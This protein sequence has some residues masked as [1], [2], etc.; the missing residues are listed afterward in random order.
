MRDIK[1]TNAASVN[2]KVGIPPDVLARQL[3]ECVQ[4]AQAQV[5][6]TIKALDQ[7]LIAAIERGFMMNS[8]VT[9]AAEVLDIAR[10][11]VVHVVLGIDEFAEAFIRVRDLLAVTQRSD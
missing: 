11:A 5:H 7:I 2:S 6:G 3:Q 4:Y 1:S 9:E 10:D 8:Q